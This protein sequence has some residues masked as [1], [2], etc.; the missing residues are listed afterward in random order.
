MNKKAIKK[1]KLFGI[2]FINGD[3]NLAY[4]KLN[5]GGLMVVPAAPALA[6]IYRDK[7]YYNAL[8]K[9]DFAIPDS[10]FMVLIL[11]LF[12]RVNIN[13]LSGVS[14]L[15]N[16]IF[17]INPSD[18]IFLIDPTRESSIINNVYLKD[19]GIVISKDDH[20]V[21]PFYNTS[22]IIDR[23]LINKLEEK[24]PKYILI[25]IGG[26]VQEPLGLYLKNNLSFKPSI[27]CTGAAIAILNGQQALM[28]N[29]IDK[30]YLGWL[31]RCLHNPS[32]FI[33]RYLK[34][35]KL[36]PLLIKEKI[37]IKKI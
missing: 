13:K 36:F 9:S 31:A 29:W 37:V 3:F 25:N 18:T 30:L 19:C 11:K 34:S 33:P 12:K 32:V 21:A 14:F 27:I 2:Q 15:R 22:N 8:L 4:N 17:K 23:V 20:Y 7:S 16:F 28:P 5:D 35:F 26:G 10:G 6:E 24:K 1:F